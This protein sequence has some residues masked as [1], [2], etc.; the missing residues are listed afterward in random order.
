VRP[1]LTEARFEAAGEPRS[2]QWFDGGHQTLPGGAMKAM[3]VF[4]REHLALS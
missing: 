2:L 1:P 3:W 4:M